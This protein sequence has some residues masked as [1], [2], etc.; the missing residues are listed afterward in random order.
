MSIST[1]LAQQQRQQQIT[2]T[3]RG[4]RQ[5]MSGEIV[6]ASVTDAVTWAEEWTRR[7]DCGSQIGR[8][9]R[10]YGTGDLTRQE[11]IDIAQ[12]ISVIT[13]QC[14]PP[15]GVAMKCVYGGYD[16]DRDI[17]L[18][19]TIGAH[20]AE[21]EPGRRKPREKL[22]KLGHVTI[23]A[24]RAWELYGDR[25]PYARM[26][27]DIGVSRQ[28]FRKGIHWPEL[29]HQARELLRAWLDR[30]I[31]QIGQALRDRGWLA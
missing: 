1:M 27:H 13:A 24:E 12:T 17:A 19:E 22:N 21:R 10:K 4:L 23:K 20:L 29:L 16:M 3:D 28:Q 8:L 31:R 7:P 25:Y 18:G 2:T 5:A 14:E 6:F 30:A 11:V 15:T 26:A 9:M